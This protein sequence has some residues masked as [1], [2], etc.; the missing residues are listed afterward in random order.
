ML[1][2]RTR[3]VLR[4]HGL[5]HESVLALKGEDGLGGHALRLLSGSVSGVVVIVEVDYVFKV[6]AVSFVGQTVL[7]SHGLDAVDHLDWEAGG[8]RRVWLFYRSSRRWVIPL[9]LQLLAPTK[10]PETAFRASFQETTSSPQCCE[11]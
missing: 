6:P 11:R 10:A 5:F 7:L 9:P 4:L 1:D 8:G 3:N 2:R